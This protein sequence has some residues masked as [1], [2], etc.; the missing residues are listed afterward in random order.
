M[1]QSDTSTFWGYCAKGDG[2]YHSHVSVIC[3]EE[4]VITQLEQKSACWY[5]VT[6]GHPK[7]CVNPVKTVGTWPEQMAADKRV[8]EVYSAGH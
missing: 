8:D 2:P 5:V 1:R 4:F 6:V 3:N 7:F